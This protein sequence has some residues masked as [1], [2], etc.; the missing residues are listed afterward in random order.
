MLD[1]KYHNLLNFDEKLHTNK[2]NFNKNK[3][4]EITNFRKS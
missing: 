1:K 2:S 3:E 4:I